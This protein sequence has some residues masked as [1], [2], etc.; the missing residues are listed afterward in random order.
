MPADVL[1]AQLIDAR[2]AAIVFKNE[3]RPAVLVYCLVQRGHSVCVHLHDVA[4]LVGVCGQR[5]RRPADCDEQQHEACS[6]SSA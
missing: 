4:A 5:S 2:D 1:C 6:H 3:A